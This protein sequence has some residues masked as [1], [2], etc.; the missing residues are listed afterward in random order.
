MAK[1][2]ATAKQIEDAFNIYWDSRTER[3]RLEKE[4]A[5]FKKAEDEAKELLT[6]AIPPNA[7][8]H[9]VFHKEHEKPT[10]GYKAYADHLITM[11]PKTKQEAATAALEDFTKKTK[12]HSFK[13]EA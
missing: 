10:V 4:A 8:L 2:K 6:Q 13:S 5:A 1:N 12:V 11:L 7:S 3:L 9:G